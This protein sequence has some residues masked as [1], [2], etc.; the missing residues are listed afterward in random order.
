MEAPVLPCKK[1][2]GPAP[3][4]LADRGYADYQGPTDPRGPPRV[5]LRRLGRPV[6]RSGLPPAADAQRASTFNMTLARQA[7]IR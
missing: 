6:A 4:Q 5:I 7:H 1:A 2:L 3:G